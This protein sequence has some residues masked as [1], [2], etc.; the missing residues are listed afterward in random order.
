MHIFYYEERKTFQIN[1]K[2]TTYAFCITNLDFIE[3]LYYGKR[4]DSGDFT[5]LSNR[6]VYTFASTIN[7]EPRAFS[8]STMLTEIS[9][10]NSTDF[11]EG[12]VCI[13]NPDE[14]V[15]NR[16][17]YKGHE[18]YEGRQALKGLPYS[19]QGKDA[20]TLK[21]RLQ[22]EEKGVLLDVYYVAYFET[23][24]IAR[25][26]EITNMT[27]KPLR[28]LKAQSLNLDIANS[29]LDLIEPIGMYLY[30][31]GQIQRNPLKRGI[32]GIKSNTNSTSH[33]ANPLF[34]LCERNATE[35]MGE[36]Y[37]FNLMYSGGF[38]N[39][40]EVDRLG[41][42]R[43][44]SGM[45]DNGFDY[46]LEKG[47]NFVSPE[48]I[49]TFSDKG[50]GQVSRN[51]H[52]HIRAHIIPAEFVHSKR[53][54]VVNSWEGSGMNVTE[55][56]ILD[57]VKGAKEVGA[58]TVV[59]DDGWFRSTIEEGLA[60]YVLDRKK[61]PNGLQ[62]LSKK[63]HEEGLQ[64][65]IWFEPECVAKNSEFIKTNGEDVLKTR[66]IP[67][68]S[69][70]QLVLDFT[71]DKVID[72]IFKKM[73]DVLDGVQVEYLKWDYNRYIHEAGSKNCPF[74]ELNYRQTLGVYKL[75]SK[76]RE[77][78]P[79]LLIESCAG[80]GGRF[81]LGI[82]YFSPQIWLSD[83]TD[84]FARAYIQYG[85]S[86]GY[87]TSSLS[88][89][90]TKGRCTS[91]RES[92]LYFRYLVAS[93]GVYGYELNVDEFTP[94]QKEEV[95]R[96]TDT[97]NENYLF[98]LDCDLYRI[99]DVNG[100]RYSAYVQVSKDKSKAMFTFIQINSKGFYEN[101]LVRLQGL[102]PNKTYIEE[103]SQKE[104]SGS[105]LMFGGIRMPN[106][107]WIGSGGGYQLVFREVVK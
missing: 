21:L 4:I 9:S 56:N 90:L 76:V 30:E 27:S 28:I 62:E 97:Y 24:V 29:E 61:F 25:H 59:L 34:M 45:N 81:D 60:D 46:T 107:F 10:D 8:E 42:T 26:I 3:H 15:G 49:M 40:I 100:D 12:S 43:I 83:N 99:I 80:G 79:D 77:R 54:V 7:D 35:Y 38:S 102:D 41:N 106:L 103:K 32:Q 52:D 5:L 87:P 63:I 19:R 51:F 18:I 72:Y 95:K 86:F 104:Y 17:T 82:L 64:F 58:D 70:E 88:C 39:Q 92:S 84:P 101:I 93:M 94:A 1:T 33:N 31:F 6:Q 89:H 20:A 91:Q 47:E 85:A 74:G 66:K 14:T 37:G 44:I 73:T 105:M 22:D 11:R 2:N 55:G 50:I 53:P 75:L 96:Y 68:L 69:R 57:L 98:S 48:G 13:V 78:Y 65:G 36:V 71:S 67:A 16:F 23:D